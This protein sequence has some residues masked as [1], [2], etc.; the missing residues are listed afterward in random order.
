MLYSFHK[1]NVEYLF[2]EATT[3][4]LDNLVNVSWRMTS[5]CY[6]GI[7]YNESSGYIGKNYISPPVTL[8]LTTLRSVYTEI[9]KPMLLQ[10]K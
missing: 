6:R 1:Y 4:V 3:N 8:N 10:I 9:I 2:S 7:D 5:A